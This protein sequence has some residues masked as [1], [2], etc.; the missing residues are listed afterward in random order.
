MA[1]GD[2][3][4]AARLIRWRVLVSERR[5]RRQV[6]ISSDDV[7]PQ[8]HSARPRP[9]ESRASS[10]HEEP[11][12]SIKFVQVRDV[13]L[14]V[15]P[16]PILEVVNQAVHEAVRVHRDGRH[17]VKAHVFVTHVSLPAVVLVNALDVLRR[18]GVY[19][20]EWRGC[21]RYSSRGSG[22]NRQA[23][24]ILGWRQG[25]LRKGTARIRDIYLCSS[26]YS[27]KKDGPQ[28]KSSVS[29]R[30]TP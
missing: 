22:E 13:Q 24:R 12:T 21:G 15:Q 8:F 3:N 25:D 18:I 10:A 16:Y 7:P 27:D 6:R 29:H 26:I 20:Y 9:S 2:V 14:A 1:C 5:L 4:N 23:E 28:Q 19:S 17:F 30:L 11:S